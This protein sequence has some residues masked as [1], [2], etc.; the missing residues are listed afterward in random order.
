MKPESASRRL[1]SNTQAKA[2]MFEFSVPAEHHVDVPVSPTRLFP[3]TIGNLGEI[4]AR[5]IDNNITEEDLKELEDS[6]PFSA[7]FFDAFAET[8]LNEEYDQYLRLVGAATYYLCNLPGSANI[9]AEQIEESHLEGLGLENLLHWLLLIKKFPTKFDDVSDSPY[10][11]LIRTIHGAFLEFSL[12][13]SRSEDA[14]VG[15]NNL[16]KLCYVIGTPRQL[17]FVDIAELSE[18]I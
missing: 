1:L 9:L 4:A 15:V 7:R 18:I 6:L 12:S 3:L 16:R 8:K 13:G 11:E 14:V 17:L 10:A 5:I 2:K